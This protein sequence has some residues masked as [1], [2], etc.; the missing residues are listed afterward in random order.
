MAWSLETAATFPDP[1]AL[2]ASFAVA[3]SSDVT[4]NGQAVERARAWVMNALTMKFERR[5]AQSGDT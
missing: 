4:G 5:V 3:G 2:H 1:S